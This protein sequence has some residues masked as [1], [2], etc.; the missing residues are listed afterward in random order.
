MY[1][2]ILIST[3]GSE[4]AQK[5]VDHGLALAK[6]LGVNVTIITVTERFQVYSG[7]VGY[8]LAW[9][10]AVLDEY[11]QGQKKAADGILSG[12]RQSAER[13]GVTVDTLHVPD[14]EVAEAIIAAAKERNCGLIVM[15]SH[16]RRGLG[17]LM[18]GSKASEVLTH[19]DIPVLIVR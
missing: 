15:A 9:S 7:V 12:A 5:G 17:R 19:S 11:A 1:K 4:V 18:L 10:G 16:G 3:D 13:L 2:R 8:D 6:A 14:A